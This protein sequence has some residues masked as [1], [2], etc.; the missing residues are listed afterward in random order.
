ESVFSRLAHQRDPVGA[1]MDDLD[2]EFERLKGL[3]EDANA[4]TSEWIDL[5]ELYWEERDE[6]LK[7][8]LD[9]ELG[10]LRDF[11]SDL[12]A[13][14]SALSLTDRKAFALAEY[15]PRAARVAAGDST[16]YADFTEA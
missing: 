14:N 11:M 1:A 3:F 15:Q 4:S 13:G 7:G 2:R 12:T 6:L 10:T 5:E 8:A 9:R 16:A